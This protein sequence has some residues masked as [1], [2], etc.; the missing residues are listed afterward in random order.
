MNNDPYPMAMP[1]LSPGVNVLDEK[2]LEA[3]T[4]ASR[5][6]PRKRMIQSIH[7]T[8]E[9]VLQRMLNCLQPGTYIRPHR[10][11]PDRAESIIVLRGSILYL[12]FSESGAVLDRV[13]LGTEYG[14]PGI[15][16][17]GGIF[18]SFIAME[19]DTVLFEVKPGPYDPAAD[20]EF[21]VWAP[22]ECSVDAEAYLESLLL[23]Q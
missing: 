10:H 15:D 9:D 17:A 16:S 2:L 5:E 1:P 20:K 22:E 14:R 6:S 12:T 21:A 3:V 18:H 8:P 7:Y 23:L 4:R 13:R 11:A 19:P